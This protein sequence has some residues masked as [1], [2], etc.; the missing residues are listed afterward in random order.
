MKQCTRCAIFRRRLAPASFGAMR[1]A[2]ICSL[3][4]VALALAFAQPPAIAAE[5]R[6]LEIYATTDLHGH[7]VPTKTHLQGGNGKRM[8]EVGGLAMIGGILKNARA[9]FPGRVMLLDGGDIMQGTL[10]SNLGEGLAMIHGMNPLGYTA[11]A[12]GNHDFDYGPVGPSPIPTQPSDDPRGALIA[13]IKDATFPMLS[14]NLMTDRGAHM[15][16]PY[17]IR[18]ID[19]V[20]V[21]IVGATTTA[22]STTT[23]PP[24]LIG[25]RVEPILPAVLAAGRAATEKGARV[26]VVVMHAGG[27][28]N[29]GPRGFTDADKDDL[30][31]CHQEEEGF[32]LA[33]GLAADMKAGGP[34]W[35]ALVGGHTHQAV[36]AIVDGIPFV[37]AGK[38][39][40]H[41]A[42][43]SIEVT[44]R[45][46]DARATGH[47]TI[48]HDIDVCAQK[49]KTDHCAA[50]GDAPVHAATYLGATIVPDEKVAAGIAHDLELAA[51]TG[52][53]SIGVDLPEGMPAGYH[54]ESP[55]GNF[56][57]DA[58]RKMAKAE[59][60]LMNGGGLRADLPPGPLTYGRLYESFPFDNQ[61]VAIEMTGAALRRSIVHNLHSRSGILSY[62]GLQVD[63]RCEAGKVLVDVLMESGKP[64]DLKAHYHVAAPDFLVR[65][66]DDAVRAAT[67]V[68]PSLGLV[69]EALEQALK[70]HAGVLHARDAAVFD[71]AHPRTRL[72]GPRPIGCGTI[73]P[74]DDSPIVDLS[75]G[76][77]R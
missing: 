42:H 19:G 66:G 34:R 50:E 73:E 29:R 21:G 59:V 48:E 24:N 18:E 23:M 25:L 1:R 41:V 68:G 64:L 11:A 70:A 14:A 32:Q 9:K 30:A 26:L 58:V 15:F 38:N 33:H 4:I 37:Q 22:L 76:G 17:V 45:G 13:R 60:G 72:P 6:N 69:R 7:L 61:V 35:S 75:S 49:N 20:P 55:L 62:S 39:G 56:A 28:C 74:H 77:K 43:V 3:C 8:G 65:G 67:T 40:E 12:I 2:Q 46:K 63:A 53:R 54:D 10:A 57:A 5:A 47:F 71:P 51:A 27:E 36:N 52:A 44:G 16:A 31:G